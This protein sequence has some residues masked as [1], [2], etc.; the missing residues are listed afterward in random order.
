MPKLF[1][2]IRTAVAQRR[3]LIGVHAGS[4]LDERGI[5]DWQVVGG[6]AEGVLLRE[7]P[8]DKPNPAVEVQQVLPDGT[9][10]KAIWSW[11]PQQEWAKLVT[12]HYLDR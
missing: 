4:Q 10:V 2:E 12:V 3:Y 8:Q 11:L 7:R 1:N 5:P 9:P 6:L